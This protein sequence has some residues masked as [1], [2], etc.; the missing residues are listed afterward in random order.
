MPK[1]KIS[2][3]YMDSDELDWEESP[4]GFEISDEELKTLKSLTK[5][6]EVASKTQDKCDEFLHYLKKKAKK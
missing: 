1:I 2:W 3:R 4:N 5:A 6:A